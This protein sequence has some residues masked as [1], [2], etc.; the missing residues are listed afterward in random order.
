MGRAV[1]NGVTE[2]KIEKD[3]TREK[4]FARE[5]ESES[6]ESASELSMRENYVPG[7]ETFRQ[8]R[9]PARS[10]KTSKTRTPISRIRTRRQISSRITRSNRLAR[11]VPPPPAR[12]EAP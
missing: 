8:R 12:R 11:R 6:T 4:N 5:S 9:R 3:I 1:G 10:A 2:K 7:A